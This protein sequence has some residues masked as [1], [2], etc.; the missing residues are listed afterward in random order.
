M[1]RLN[2]SFMRLHGASSMANLISLGAMVYYGAM[3]AEK[4]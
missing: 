2:K 1:E 4:I 3:L